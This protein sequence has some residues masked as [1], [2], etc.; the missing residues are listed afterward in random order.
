MRPNF[1]LSREDMLVGRLTKAHIEHN[2]PLKRVQELRKRRAGGR[3]TA[4]LS[5]SIGDVSKQ[6]ALQKEMKAQPPPKRKAAEQES[7]S[8]TRPKK[9]ATEHESLSGTRPKRRRVTPPPH[10]ATP[11][12]VEEPLPVSSIMHAQGDVYMPQ[13]QADYYPPFEYDGLP[14]VPE[15]VYVPTHHLARP[16]PQP[17][18]INFAAT[19]T[20]PRRKV[21]G[22][23][24]HAQRRP[25]PIKITLS[26]SRRQSS[27]GFVTVTRGSSA[28]SRRSSARLAARRTSRTSSASLAD[29]GRALVQEAEGNGAR[30]DG[31]MS[32]VSDYGSLFGDEPR[33]EEIE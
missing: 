18:F 2:K 28:D 33:I 11:R 4:N 23:P 6:A 20:S 24:R 29:I 17:Q 31:E 3:I 12:V 13:F 8:G 10:M 27:A 22:T 7:S 16:M 26:P 25:S 1:D 32:P 15:A 14:A 30:E 19:R 21:M 9:Q 5:E